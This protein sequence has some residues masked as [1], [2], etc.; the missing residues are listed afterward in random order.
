MIK[1]KRIIREGEE[2]EL[3]TIDEVAKFLRYQT[4]TVWNQLSDDTFPLV[5]IY[6]LGERGPRFL[7]DEVVDLVNKAIRKRD[8]SLEGGE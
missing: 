6:V 5:P 2:Y 7:E 3:L 4:K 1:G 8:K